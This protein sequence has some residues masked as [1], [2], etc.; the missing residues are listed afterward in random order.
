MKEGL[1]TQGKAGSEE[2]F[3]SE[4]LDDS[5]DQQT[6]PVAPARVG[7]ERG[8]GRYAFVF[9]LLGGLSLLGLYGFLT[10]TIDPSLLNRLIQYSSVQTIFAQPLRVGV[11]TA[12]ALLAGLWIARKR[13]H[14]AIPK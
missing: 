7:K 10:R 3:G 14:R 11:I 2:V 1:L 12:S 6:A 4:V 13:K 8:L 5:R 9:M